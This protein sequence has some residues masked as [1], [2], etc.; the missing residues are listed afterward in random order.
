VPSIVQG[1]IGLADRLRAHSRNVQVR[2]GADNV[3]VI[4]IRGYLTSVNPQ[5]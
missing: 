2:E 3:A 5:H 4:P 1:G